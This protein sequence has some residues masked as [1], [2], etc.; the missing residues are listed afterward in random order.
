QDDQL[1][2][3]RDVGALAV[4]AREYLSALGALRLRVLALRLGVEP[5]KQSDFE[6]RHAAFLKVKMGPAVGVADRPVHD[7]ADVPLPVA[8]RGRLARGGYFSC[9]RAFHVALPSI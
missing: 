9:R 5:L 1:A 3:V 8:R 6:Q 2:I 7:L 4:K